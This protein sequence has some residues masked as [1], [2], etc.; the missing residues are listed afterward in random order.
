MKMPILDE[1]GKPQFL[2]GIS[3]D[4]TERKLAEQAI[5]ELNYAC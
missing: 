2:L 4:I 5:R 1:Q 3:E